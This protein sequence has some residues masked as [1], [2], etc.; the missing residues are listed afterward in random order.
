MIEMN[1][2]K[3]QRL[4]N[5]ENKLIVARGLEIGSFGWACTYCCI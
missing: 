5:L 3:K 1:L 4:T 2:L